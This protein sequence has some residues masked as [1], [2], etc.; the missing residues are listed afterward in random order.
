MIAPRP[1]RADSVRNQAGILRAARSLIR[2]GGPDVGMDEIAR[3]AGVAVGT[4]YRHFPSKDDLVAAIVRQIAVQLAE[5]LDAAV[6]RI[7]HGGRARDE[8]VSLFTGFA[9]IVGTD[10]ALKLA[11]SRLGAVHLEVTEQMRGLQQRVTATLTRIVRA[12]H[13]QGDLH[14]D[15]TADD[16]TLLL[17][18]LP[19]GE[20][21]EAD[22]QRW[23]QLALRG[24]IA[25]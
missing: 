7:D 25:R 13:L 17:A 9:E 21:P 19:G 22:R 18:A 11:I 3:A 4:L 2:S 24:L 16:V 12:A 5:D 15:V 8:L 10:R 1:V 20:L 23:V 14:P 6:A